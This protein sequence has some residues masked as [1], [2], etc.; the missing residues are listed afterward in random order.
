MVTITLNGQDFTPTG[1]HF[2][3]YAHPSQ[4]AVLLQLEPLSGPT[5]GSTAVHVRP[6]GGVSFGCHYVCRFG[7]HSAVTVYHAVDQGGASASFLTCISPAHPIGT[8]NMSLSL[9]GAQFVPLT[10]PGEGFTYY[11][12]NAV[13]SISP[14]GGPISGG[15]RVHLG[16]SWQKELSRLSDLGLVE[17]Q[18][19]LR[20]RFGLETVAA[21]WAGAI[22]GHVT[23]L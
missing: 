5:R 11:P 10:M 20:C 16:G 12:E 3:R 9:N 6:P 8:V 13:T 15:T 22:R 4:G 18:E 2:S 21:S 17:E 19:V 7:G 14:S 1:P 23:A